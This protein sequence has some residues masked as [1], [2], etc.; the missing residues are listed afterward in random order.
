MNLIK[1]LIFD[2]GDVFINLDKEG[3]MANALEIFEVDTFP[4]EL[5]HVNCRYEMGLITTKAFLEFYAT[6]FPNLKQGTILHAWNC[7]LRDFPKHRLAFLKKL[8]AEKKYNLILL[9]NT[10]ELHIDWIKNEIPFYEEFK[11]C[12]NRFYLSHEIN[13]RKPNSNIYEFVLTE[14]NLT[15][16]ECLFVDDLKE[17]TDSASK[18]GINTWNINPETDDVTQLFDVNKRLF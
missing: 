14:N 3:A 10:N 8:Q 17:N 18:L 16:S 15:P 9:S 6:K 4:E 11:S 12:F 1:T 5:T 7:I 13:L 2:F